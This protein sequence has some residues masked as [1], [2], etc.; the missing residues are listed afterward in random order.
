MPNGLNSKAVVEL[1]PG[2]VL[3]TGYTI[4]HIDVMPTMSGKVCLW[5]TAD[6]DAARVRVHPYWMEASE[7]VVLKGDLTT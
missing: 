3:S 7:H 5:L 2:D 1:Q 4:D 6:P